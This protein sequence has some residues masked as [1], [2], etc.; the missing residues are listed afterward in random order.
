MRLG[1]ALSGGMISGMQKKTEVNQSLVAGIA[2]VD[3]VVIVVAALV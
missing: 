2:V 1:D 3:V